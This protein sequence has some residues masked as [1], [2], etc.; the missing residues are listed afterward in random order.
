M[1]KKILNIFLV[2]FLI[3]GSALPQEQTIEQKQ[4]ELISLRNEISELQR[5]L[6]LQ[7][8]KER[9]SYETIENLNRQIFL[10][11][12]LINNLKKEE[13]LKEIEIVNTEKKISDLKN[14]IDLIKKNYEQDVVSVYKYGKYSELETLLNSESVRQALARIK[15]LQRFSEKRAE[16]LREIEKRKNELTLAEEQMKIEK[17]EKSKLAEAKKEEEA[18]LKQSLGLKNKLLTGIKEDKEIIE[19]ELAAR[20]DAEVKIQQLI[21]KLIEEAERKKQKQ[22]ISSTENKDSE[23]E[24]INETG[25]AGYEID[26]STEEFASFS[27]MKGKLSWP[28][29]G[30]RVIRKFGENRNPKLNTV[31]INYGIDIQ[32][33]ADLNV[34]AVAEGVVSAI[35]FVPGYGSVIIISHKGNFRTVYSHLSQIFV[36]EGDVVKK[37]KVIAVVG[38]GIEGN[39]LHFEIW[40]SRD[41]QNPEQW[42]SRK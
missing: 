40:N 36:S 29:Q 11:N 8:K 6:E 32:A 24:I 38:E 16:D 20:K 23:N 14:E 5:Q 33:K 10:L 26:L 42:L 25:V 34:K 30:G 4:T 17:L 3:C 1:V 27:E 39:I 19:K 18:Q 2:S 31:T 15:Y 21:V 7:T 9:E 12:K 22:M 13:K 37:G 35:D 41:T 28:L